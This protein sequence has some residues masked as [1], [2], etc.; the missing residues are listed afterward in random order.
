MVLP[1]SP[2]E[3]L[4]DLKG[5]KLAFL[6]PGTVPNMCSAPSRERRKSPRKT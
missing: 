4:D 3:T 2:I 5:K 1:D 6:G